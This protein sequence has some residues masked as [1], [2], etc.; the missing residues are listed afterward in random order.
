[1][2]RVEVFGGQVRYLK[3]GV[4]FHSST[5]T[6]TYPLLLDTSL[7]DV[8]ATIV[9]AEIRECNESDRGCIIPGM[10]KNVRY[11]TPAAMA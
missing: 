7:R 2:F 10:W 8:G 1:V 9:N 5:R 11:A 6:P 4:V 3:N